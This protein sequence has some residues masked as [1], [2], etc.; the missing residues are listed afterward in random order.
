MDDAM[1]YDVIYADPPWT[2]S[3]YSPKG[4]GR[5]A[6]AHYPCMTLAEIAALPVQQWAA[7]ASVLYL[8]ATV[9]HL[10]NALSM[11]EAWGL[12]LLPF[13]NGRPHLVGLETGSG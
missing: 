8:W 3:I 13:S 11:I 2:F 7:Q 1:K 9:P 10:A 5:S 6:E 12:P 4:K